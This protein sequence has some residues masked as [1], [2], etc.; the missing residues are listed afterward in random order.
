MSSILTNYAAMSAVRAL[1]ATQRSLATTQQQVSTGLRV[2][3]AQDNASY[4]SIATTMRSDIGALG[5]VQDSI[6]LTQSIAQVTS[7]AVNQIMSLVQG[8]AQDLVSAQ[9]TGIS[10]DV[11]QQDVA[12]RQ[13]QIVQ[14]A[15]S[16]TFNG[17]NWLV[18]SK[19]A[20]VTVTEH[21]VLDETYAHIEQET[22]DN[23]QPLD[24]P[25]ASPP[26]KQT[27]TYDGQTY[28]DYPL[29][30]STQPQPVYDY[31][32]AVTWDATADETDAAGNSLSQTLSYHGDDL[33][34]TYTYSGWGGRDGIN[35]GDPPFWQSYEGQ[36]RSRVSYQTPTPA[37]FTTTG[38]VDF[39]GVEAD[40][41][42]V[43]V[44]G[45]AV[46][47]L[48]VD[49]SQFL[50][51][52]NYTGTTTVAED[53]TDAAGT[54]VAGNWTPFSDPDHSFT[55]T[56]A[57]ASYN[58]DNGFSVDPGAL[59]GGL[60]VTNAANTLYTDP[61]DT[62]GFPTKTSV[63]NVDIR[64]VSLPDM[65]Q[66]VEADLASLRTISAKLGALTSGLDSQSTFV[67]SISDA[68]TAGV[69]SLVDADMNETSTRLAALQTQQ[70]LG[71]QSLA[72]AN[73]NTQVLL[74]L[75]GVG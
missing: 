4:W 9:S 2:G 17:V 43:G 14:V 47:T 40:N 50:L 1:T 53:T 56:T 33:D 3:S 58:A 65:L 19:T 68:L 44:A 46:Q 23:T 22:V 37:N 69:G 8:I 41:V 25:P 28:Y 63:L 51:F 24:P 20:A 66:A 12:Q 61:E 34:E 75:F 60:G 16:A 73:D 45:S 52:T 18:G 27:F 57:Y 10:L 67:S 48:D 55:K 6:H 5:A 30:G 31:H 29:I 26:V 70:Q 54:T 42:P 32:D 7:A 64:T 72:I 59:D 11:L 74:K 49:T 38:T 15:Q 35:P 62:F 71:L 39:R 21:H 36:V 13:A